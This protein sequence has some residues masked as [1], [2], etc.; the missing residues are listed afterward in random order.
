MKYLVHCNKMC[1]IGKKQKNR[2]KHKASCHARCSL[3]QLVFFLFI[4]T[5]V[6]TY[7]EAEFS[8]FILY[9]QSLLTFHEA[10][11][12]GRKKKTHRYDARFD[13]FI[14][15]M[16]S[17]KHR[18]DKIKCSKMLMQVIDCRDIH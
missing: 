12:A 15:E 10:V 17:S 5:T 18:R 6:R 16:Q 9:E 1:Q 14:L 7:Y 8:Q 2:E 11:C 3:W 13:V 4:V